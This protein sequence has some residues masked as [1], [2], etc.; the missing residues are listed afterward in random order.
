MLAADVPRDFSCHFL[1]GEFRGVDR[2]LAPECKGLL[3]SVAHQGDGVHQFD[4]LESPGED[5]VLDVFGYLI[6]PRR[7]LRRV[8]IILEVGDV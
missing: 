8:G 7:H 3:P 4:S 5:Q 6:H 2:V 1:V